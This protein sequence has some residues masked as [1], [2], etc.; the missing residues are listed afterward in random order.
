[1]VNIIQRVIYKRFTNRYF[2]YFKVNPT[3]T[4]C[5]IGK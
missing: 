1:M 4:K 5:V 3:V 2:N